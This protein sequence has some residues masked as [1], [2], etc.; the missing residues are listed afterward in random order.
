MIVAFERKLS[1]LYAHLFVGDC[2]DPLAYL[3]QQGNGC[4]FT[5]I[6]QAHYIVRIYF[7]RYSNVRA[8]RDLRRI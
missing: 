1:A 2:F 4:I 6:E 3:R 5:I 7:G 8:N